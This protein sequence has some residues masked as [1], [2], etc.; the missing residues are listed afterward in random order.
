[1]P[2]SHLRFY[3]ANKK[4]STQNRDVSYE[5]TSSDGLKFYRRAHWLNDSLMNLASELPDPEAAIFIRAQDAGRFRLR[6]VRLGSIL[7][8]NGLAVAPSS[9][10]DLRRGTRS[11]LI[12]RSVAL[13]FNYYDA[14]VR[15]HGAEAR[16][17][18]LL[19][20]S[21]ARKDI[22]HS[23]ILCNES[24]APG[25]CKTESH[26]VHRIPLLGSRGEG[27]VGIVRCLYPEL[28]LPS[29]HGVEVVLQ[30]VL[31]VKRWKRRIA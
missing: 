26:L 23:G 25:R 28:D 21:T 6:H 13:R 14:F 27:D 9:D 3:E 19:I 18:R 11:F 30:F 29:R 24:R 8:H 31:G 5:R 2:L 4:I 1:M 17:T 15:R 7:A 22:R 20:R 16:P 12:Q 10:E